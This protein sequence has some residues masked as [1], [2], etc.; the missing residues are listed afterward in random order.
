[1]LSQQIIQT[2]YGK[3]NLL[4]C[5]SLLISDKVGCQIYECIQMNHIFINKF[6]LY[7]SVDVNLPRK[8]MGSFVAYF[9][10]EWPGSLCYWEL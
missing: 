4:Y 10:C 5:Y 3:V 2:K 6:C 7:L 8:A 9:L 1:M